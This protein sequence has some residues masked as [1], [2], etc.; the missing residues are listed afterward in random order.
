M[1][2]TPR[3]G[4]E[5]QAIPEIDYG[6]GGSFPE[7]DTIKGFYWDLN[8]NFLYTQT[9]TLQFN[10]FLNVPQSVAQQLVFSTAH[11]T[12]SLY[13]AICDTYQSCLLD[14][15]CVP[16]ITEDGTYIVV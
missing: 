9:P 16:F 15:N 14:E 4:G 1:S 12:E 13:A 2:I 5:P 10:I 3:N 7:S 6:W 8:T 11:P